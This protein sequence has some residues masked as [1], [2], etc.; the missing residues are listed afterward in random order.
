M[1]NSGVAHSHAGGDYRTRRAECERAAAALGVPQLRDLGVEDLPRVDRLPDPLGRRARHVV[2]ENARV[3]DA[4]AA[5]Q[6]GDLR[7]L[8]ALFYASHAS[9]RDDFEVSVPEIDLLVALAQAEPASTARGSPAGASAGR[10]S[11]S[12]R[13]MRRRASRA[14][15]RRLPRAQRSSGDC[16]GPQPAM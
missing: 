11:R 2:T 12:S 16:P 15:R 13:W 5:L 6:A 9:L 1:I 14:S 10:S 7:R 3:L 8:G 4:V